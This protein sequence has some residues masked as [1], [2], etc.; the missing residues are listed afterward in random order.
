[1]NRSYSKLR[2]IQ[3][4]NLLIEQRVSK[5][6]KAVDSGLAQLGID[7]PFNRNEP[8][9]RADSE[10]LSK[11]QQEPVDSKYDLPYRKSK[12]EPLMTPEEEAEHERKIQ[13]E[14]SDLQSLRDKI[15]AETPLEKQIEILKNELVGKQVTFYQ[16]AAEKYPYILQGIKIIDVKLEFMSLKISFEDGPF[17][18]WACN[19]SSKTNKFFYDGYGRKIDL[20]QKQL[21]ELLTKAICT[22]SRGGAPILKTGGFTQNKTNQPPNNLA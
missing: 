4:C 14:K 11:I 22:T 12:I 20:Y 8:N 19:D 5:E 13:K 6:R 17:A 18:Y 2:H 7:S 3:E 9:N 16:D 10:Q 1:M 21:S 15:N